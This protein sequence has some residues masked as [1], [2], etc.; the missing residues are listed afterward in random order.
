MKTNIDKRSSAVSALLVKYFNEE[1]MA[2]Y[3]Y[4][5]HMKSKLLVDGRE[6]S[7]KIQNGEHQMSALRDAVKDE[8]H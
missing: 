4:F 3:E 8:K 6:I 5:V 1:E 2:E 7:E